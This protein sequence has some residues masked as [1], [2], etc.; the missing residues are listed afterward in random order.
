MSIGRVAI[1]IGAGIVV[2]A[3]IVA[4]VEAIGHGFASDD[5]TFVAALAA[6]A[7]GAAG[8]VALFSRIAGK[9]RLSLAIPLLLGGLALVN[10][11]AFPHPWWFTPAAVAALAA[12]WYVGRGGLASRPG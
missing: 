5:G 10:M 1:G 11:A 6:L 3:L 8:G 7:L 9:G 12:G 2:S 4:A